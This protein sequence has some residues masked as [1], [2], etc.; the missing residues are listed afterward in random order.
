MTEL[1]S[2]EKL[3][4]SWIIHVD[5]SSNVAGSGTGLLLLGPEE[6]IAKYALRFDFPTTYNEAE[7]K[8]ILAGLRITKELGI[9]KLKI[10]IDLQLVADQVKGDFEAREENMKKYLQKVKDLTSKFFYFDIQ[11]IPRSENS[12]AD[13]L[14]KLAT[15]SFPNGLPKEHS[16]KF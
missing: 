4:D 9:Q 13:L 6:F 2:S 7:Y 10:Y 11:Q 14:S 12:R 5:G 3:T 15:T 1:G 8:A 16:L